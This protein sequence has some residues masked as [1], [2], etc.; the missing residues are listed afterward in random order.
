MVVDDTP[1]DVEGSR[2]AGHRNLARSPR[3]L[4]LRT[5]SAKQLTAQFQACPAGL[6]APSLPH[7]HILIFHLHLNFSHR[8]RAPNPEKRTSNALPRCATSAPKLLLLATS[9]LST[10][11]TLAIATAPRISSPS[12]TE[13][14]KNA[15]PTRSSGDIPSVS[16]FLPR[17]RT[18]S[19]SGILSKTAPRARS[20]WT[21]FA[22]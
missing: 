2:E 16:S 9:S 10:A 13:S 15:P 6:A 22:R 5:A 17:Y 3:T 21:T 14:P 4:P 7:H 12:R 1:E 20:K 8:P 19:P 18:I 11:L